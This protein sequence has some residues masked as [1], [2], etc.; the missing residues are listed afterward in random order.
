[1]GFKDNL[2]GDL[3]APDPEVQRSV[4]G[5]PDD[6]AKSFAGELGDSRRPGYD[7]PLSVGVGQGTKGKIMVWICQWANLIGGNISIFI[8]AGLS[9]QLN[10]QLTDH[11]S[12]SLTG[13]F[14]ILGGVAII[15]T[16]LP[17]FHSLRYINGISMCCTY[18]FT[19]IAFSL[20]IY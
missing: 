20:A 10:Y 9:L 12:V 2:H 15:L 18:C 13:W 3:A 6:Y 1:M 14:A 17:T 7:E 16:Q 5:G 19:I 11:N 4:K 8:Q